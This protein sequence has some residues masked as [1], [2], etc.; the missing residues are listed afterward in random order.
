MEVIDIEMLKYKGFGVRIYRRKNM[1]DF[2]DYKKDSFTFEDMQD[3]VI[4]SS[5]VGPGPDIIREL[6][7]ENAMKI[8]NYNKPCLILFRNTSVADSRYY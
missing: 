1:K 8:F 5:F 4:K 3:F 2:K 6:S 7:S